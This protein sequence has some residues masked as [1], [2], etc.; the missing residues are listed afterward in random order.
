M[1]LVHV[2][3]G[4]V[5]DHVGLRLHRL[6]ERA[7]PLDGVGQA[8]PRGEQRMA[9]A[10]AL[11]ATHEHLGA[12]VQVQLPDAGPRRAHGAEAGEQISMVGT[13]PDHEG[14]P[15]GGR[16]WGP[17]ELD[18]LGDELRGQVVDDEPTEVLERIR[19]L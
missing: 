14:D 11:V 17:D 9:P 15:R 18:H 5:D 12:G 8:L 3:G 16:A 10:G 19:R 1:Q 2:E 4:G 13:G 6:E 7:L